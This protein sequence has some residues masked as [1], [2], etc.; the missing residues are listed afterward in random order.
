M[1]EASSSRDRIDVER[2]RAELPFGMHSRDEAVNYFAWQAGLFREIARGRIIDHGA[3]TGGL[4]GAMLAAGA[5]EVVA[6]DP[7][8]LLVAAMRE[9]FVD[10]GEVSVFAGTLDDYLATNGRAT[11]D[12]VISSNVIEHIDDDVAC[13]RAMWDVL[14]PGGGVGIYVPARPELFGSLDVAV[15]HVRRYARRELGR[16]L[17]EA[18]FEVRF[19]RYCNLVAVLPWIVAGQILKRTQIG[20]GSIRAFDRVVFPI[21][22]RLEAALPLPYGLN[23]AAMAIK[24]E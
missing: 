3:G 5:R 2:R 17:R 19:V 7:D 1:T 8:P 9:R 10:R 20:R 23:L 4:A 14:R 16:K 12:C 18:G 11:A 15:G 6:L 22:S 24:R 21:A 13:L